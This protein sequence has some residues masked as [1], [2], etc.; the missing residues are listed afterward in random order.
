[1]LYCRPAAR[2]R[3]RFRRRVYRRPQSTS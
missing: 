2:S 1:V 3:E